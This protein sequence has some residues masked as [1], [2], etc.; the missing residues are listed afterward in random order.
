MSVY[1]ADHIDALSA[2]QESGMAVTF[3]YRNP[4]TLDAATGLYTGSSTTTV[5]GYAVR[6]RGNP[7]TYDRLTLKQSEAPSLFFVPSTFGALPLPGYEVTMGSVKY[8]VRDVDPVAP[9]GTALAARIVVS[10]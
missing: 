7:K 8:T 10:R 3:T 4:G 6:T 1:T 5:S 2:V 9:D